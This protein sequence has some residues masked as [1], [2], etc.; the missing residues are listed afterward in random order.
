MDAEIG[1]GKC[2]KVSLTAG[3]CVNAVNYNGWA[4][5]HCA[6]SE[7]LP[8]I[9]Q[10]LLSAGAHVNAQTFSQHSPLSLAAERG[11]THIV[12][13]LLTAGA[14]IDSRT[15]VCMLHQ[16]VMERQ[17]VIKLLWCN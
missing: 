10:I 7:G 15:A 5:L 4:A 2:L 3:A 6:A 11:N 1:D 12:Q 9:V 8:Q 13:L 16:A 14:K 17:N